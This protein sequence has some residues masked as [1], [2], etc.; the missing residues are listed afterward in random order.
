MTVITTSG[1]LATLL[2]ALAALTTREADTFSLPSGAQD[3]LEWSLVA[4]AIAAL[5]SI[6]TQLPLKYEEASA[7]G[8]RALVESSWDDS[9]EVAQDVV[10]RNRLT[11]LKRARYVN[12][13]KAWA[14]FAAVFAEALAVI[15]LAVAMTR[16]F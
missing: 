12:G 6:F 2:L 15:A 5:M 10:A 4:F 11:V 7:R 8:L 13:L 1:T 3:S 9:E 14:L 16:V